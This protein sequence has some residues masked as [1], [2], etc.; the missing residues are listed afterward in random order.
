MR[1]V[2]FME[3]W[4]SYGEREHALS[5][6]RQIEQA[7]HEAHFV[8]E[9][10]VVDHIRAAGLAATPFASTEEGLAIVREL[11]PG[12]VVGCELFNLS[13][14]AVK[15]L[16]A[17]GRPMATMDGTTLGIE[18]NTDPFRT[19]QLT[20]SLT[21]PERFYSFRPCPVNEVV[22]ATDT[23][24][25]FHLCPDATRATRDAALY[26]SLGLDPGRRTV[27]LPLALWAMQAMKLAGLTRYHDRL[28]EC[29][30][31]GLEAAGLPVQLLII[32][33]NSAGAAARGSLE[34]R[35]TDLL[36][37]EVY[38]HLLRSCD[39]ILSDNIIQTSVSKAVALGIPHLIIQNMGGAGPASALPAELPYRCNIFPVRQIFPPEREYARIVEVAEYGDPAEIRDKLVAILHRGHADD[40]RA[41]RRRDY[42][43]RLAR[44]PSAGEILARIFGPSR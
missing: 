19:P 15:G 7:G 29:V 24:F 23:I 25:P 26:A 34:I 6:A 11:D 5:F 28:V 10:R 39:L 31:A 21:L 9:P 40:V 22:D 14:E 36:P 37:Y 3:I 43:A 42:V 30:G 27:L 33:P 12:L 1:V 35:V 38:D 2:F 17:L 18:V 41:E 20:R 13:A 44:L 16:E 32:A 4:F 8:V